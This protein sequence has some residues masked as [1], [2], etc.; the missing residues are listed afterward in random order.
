MAEKNESQ[1]GETSLADTY[2]VGVRFQPASKAYH[3]SAPTSMDI[4]PGAWV[5]V[6]TVY[7]DQV[8]QVVTLSYEVPEGKSLKELKP[9]LRRASGLDM[10]RYQLMQE[11]AQ[12]MLE[13]AKEEIADLSLELKVVSAEFTLDGSSALVLCSGPFNRK[14]FTALRRRLASRMRCR[15][16][17]RNVGPRDQAKAMD[18][19]GVCGGPRCCGRFLIEFQTVS[20]RMAKDQAVSM[21]PSDITGMCGRLRC[22]LAYEHQVYKEASQGFPRMRARVQTDRGLGRVVDW[23]ILKGIIV[24]EIPPEGPKYERQR[25]RY[26]VEDVEVVQ[27]KQQNQPKKK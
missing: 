24:V 25:F 3:F 6:E 13:V 26:R 10:A 2:V 11:R 19:Y 8:G 1:N 23:D 16:D 14:G 27:P 5:V 18:G 22:C 12:R 20:I 4:A 15:V 7:G 17:L 9:V 21:S